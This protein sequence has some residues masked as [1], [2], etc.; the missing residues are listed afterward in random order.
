MR[1]IVAC[2]LVALLKN[3]WEFLEMH[4]TILPRTKRHKGE[5][6]LVTSIFWYFRETESEKD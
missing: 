1:Q 5:N 4:W 6:W 3:P 2:Y